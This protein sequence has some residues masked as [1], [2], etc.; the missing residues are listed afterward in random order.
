[1][2]APQPRVEQTLEVFERHRTIRDYAPE[3]LPP[4]DLQRILQAGRRAPS[5]ATGFMYTVI[6][7]TDA[8]KRAAIAALTGK[9]PHIVS[10]SEFF[11]V[12]LDFHRM[13]RLLERRGAP[14]A[15]LGA[16]AFLFGVTDA[17]LVAENLAVAAEALGYGT[18][19]IGG[20]QR[21]ALAIA[22]LL[23]CPSGVFPV[24]GLTMGVVARNP[25]ERKRL[26]LEVTFHENVYTDLRD[27]DLDGCF[28]A[29]RSA[30]GKFDWEA[31]IKRYFAEGGEMH[32][33]EA[34]IRRGLEEQGIFS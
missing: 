29:M 7:V 13:A 5:D 10:A 1:M 27:D 25:E 21:D 20:V 17:I 23:E 11:V 15:P 16:W 22:K 6:R 32:S 30:S 9:N 4:D 19:F 31:S 12:C 14:P 8:N 2:T 34:T 18:G 26:P 3:K 24:V 33:R 28:A